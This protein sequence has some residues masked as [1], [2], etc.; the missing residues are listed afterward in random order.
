MSEDNV[1]F[2]RRTCFGQAWNAVSRRQG[3]L[4]E[5]AALFY[6]QTVYLVRLSNYLAY[7]VLRGYPVD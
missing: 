4:T 7:T 3:M 5:E 1:F 2:M 6:K